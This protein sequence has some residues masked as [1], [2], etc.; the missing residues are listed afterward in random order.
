M[1]FIHD[2]CLSMKDEESEIKMIRW[3]SSEHWNFEYYREASGISYLEYESRIKQVKIL[4]EKYYDPFFDCIKIIPTYDPEEKVSLTE[5]K[6]IVPL[7]FSWENQMELFR[8]YENFLLKKY[9]Q[10][11]EEIGSS[12]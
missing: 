1:F 2:W 12:W 11:L 7:P 4:R 8:L 3:F 5:D 9:V 10:A 6:I